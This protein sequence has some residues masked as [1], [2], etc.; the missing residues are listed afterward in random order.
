MT[1]APGARCPIAPPG[2][3]SPFRS[4]PRPHHLTALDK[5]R[6]LCNRAQSHKRLKNS[7]A[8]M[9]QLLLE[10]IEELVQSAGNDFVNLGVIQL[11]SETSQALLHQILKG[12]RERARNRMQRFFGL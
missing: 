4:S 8:N 2:L 1:T 5:G 12:A 7:G 9:I 11:R 10:G 6:N 3:H